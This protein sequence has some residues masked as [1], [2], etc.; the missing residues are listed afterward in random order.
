VAVSSVIVKIAAGGCIVHG[1]VSVLVEKE[2]CRLP[3][4]RSTQVETKEVTT[5][6]QSQQLGPNLDSAIYDLRVD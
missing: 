2:Q 6:I 5:N 1:S 4:A 3:D